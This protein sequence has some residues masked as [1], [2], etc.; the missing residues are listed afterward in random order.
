[1]S[2]TALEDQISAHQAKVEELLGLPEDWF[3]ESPPA[4]RPRRVAA[5]L[6][7]RV[8]RTFAERHGAAVN[9]VVPDPDDPG[10]ITAYVFA[11]DIEGGCGKRLASICC[12]NDGDMIVCETDYE[13]DNSDGYEVSADGLDGVTDRVIAFLKGEA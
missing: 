5:D 13:G 3:G 12:D 1:M 7:M 6:A 10:G 11:G 8:V 4:P 2:A 9:R